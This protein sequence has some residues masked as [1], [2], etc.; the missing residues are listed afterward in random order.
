[1]LQEKYFPREIIGA[2]R[3]LIT[4]AGYTAALQH[5]RP[6]NEASHQD[7]ENCE[8]QQGWNGQIEAHSRAAAVVCAPFIVF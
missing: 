3:L 1:V 4:E 7:D 2:S 8:G 6:P 5:I